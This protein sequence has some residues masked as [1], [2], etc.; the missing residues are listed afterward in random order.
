M[1]NIFLHK[2]SRYAAIGAFLLLAGCANMPTPTS[3][4]PASTSQLPVPPTHI[5]TPNPQLESL[6]DLYQHVKSQRYASQEASAELDSALAA[7][8]LGETANKD[9]DEE[10]LQH[11]IFMA[12]KNLD[13]AEVKIQLYKAQQQISQ[14]AEA[15]RAIILDAR[16]HGSAKAKAAQAR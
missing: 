3:Q 5:P 9:H 1:A 8:A 13:I 7:L 10:A 12:N 6:Q 2:L 15:R 4:T 11:Y 14:A 16:E